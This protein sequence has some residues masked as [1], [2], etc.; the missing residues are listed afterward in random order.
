MDKGRLRGR[1]SRTD[2]FAEGEEFCD[3]LLTRDRAPLAGGEWIPP[4]RNLPSDLESRSRAGL[5]L[6]NSIPFECAEI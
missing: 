6:A 1:R 4:R 5:F 2:V 3:H